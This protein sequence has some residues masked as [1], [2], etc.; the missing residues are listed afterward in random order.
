MLAHRAELHSLRPQFDEAKLRRQ[1]DVG[2]VGDEEGN[3]HKL[4]ERP[5]VAGNPI[6]KML[7]ISRKL[8]KQKSKVGNESE[9]VKGHQGHGQVVEDV[10]DT[11]VRGAG[12]KL[13][14]S[15]YWSERLE[16]RDRQRKQM[17]RIQQGKIGEEVRLFRKMRVVMVHTVMFCIYCVGLLASNNTACLS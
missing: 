15:P 11:E 10:A 12:R 1:R 14:S 3:K 16:D 7:N 9:E 17:K 6:T 8:S 5:H 2:H 4:G 13:L